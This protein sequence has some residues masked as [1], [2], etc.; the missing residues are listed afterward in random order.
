MK[1]LNIIWPQILS[2]IFMVPACAFK[3]YL[4][5]KKQVI[6]RD[7]DKCYEKLNTHLWDRYA[8]ALSNIC[9]TLMF[10]SG[11]PLLYILQSL[12]HLVQYWIDKV[13]SSFLLNFSNKI[14]ETSTNIWC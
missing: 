13:L 12:F 5:G 8:S 2:I 4:F 1:G 10:S 14:F 11:M 3:R 9:Y 7:M 6:Q